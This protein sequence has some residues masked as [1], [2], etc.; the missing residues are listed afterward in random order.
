M[1]LA[2][3][4]L[5]WFPEKNPTAIATGVLTNDVITIEDIRPAVFG[6]KNILNALIHTNDLQGC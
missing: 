6:I 3:V 2:G 4:D 5:A 1:V